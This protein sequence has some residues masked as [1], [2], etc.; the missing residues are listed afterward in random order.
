MRIDAVSDNHDKPAIA[1]ENRGG[2]TVVVVRARAAG[3]ELEV[4]GLPPGRYGL[5]FV[6]ENKQARELGAIGIERGGTLRTRIPGPGA[7]NAYALE[8]HGDPK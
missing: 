8:P 6:D 3:G 1:F 2:G 4:R 7:L 5:R